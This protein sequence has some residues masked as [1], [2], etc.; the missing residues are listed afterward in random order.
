MLSLT[1]PRPSLVFDGYS[2]SIHPLTIGL[3]WIAVILGITAA[4]FVAIKKLS[5]RRGAE[6]S[7]SASQMLA[8]F[9]DLHGRGGLSDEEFSTIRGKLGPQVQVE[10]DESVGGS[11]MADAAAA[12]QNAAALATEGLSDR[13]NLEGRPGRPDPSEAG[14]AGDRSAEANGAAG[15]GCDADP[16]VG[17]DSTEDGR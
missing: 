12:L 10:A 15:E 6:Q 4:T 3:A 7:A 5:R 17:G 1:D 16:P 11:S 8:Q 14:G 13:G 2:V 9:R